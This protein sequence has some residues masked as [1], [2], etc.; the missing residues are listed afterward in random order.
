MASMASVPLPLCGGYGGYGGYGGISSVGVGVRFGHR[1][2]V[3]RLRG[4]SSGERPLACEPRAAAEVDQRSGNG[5]G[6]E[7]GRGVN[8]VGVY[9]GGGVE[10]GGGGPERGAAGVTAVGGADGPAG[11]LDGGVGVG[12][13]HCDSDGDVVQECRLLYRSRKC[14]GMH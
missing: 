4:D 3:E 6:E 1:R 5:D 2:L 14:D 8:G 9:G 13:V 11:V 7:E 12:E 10:D